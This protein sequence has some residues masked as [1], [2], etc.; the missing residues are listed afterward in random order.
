[1]EIKRGEAQ[2]DRVRVPTMVA[3]GA[4]RWL[5]ITPYFL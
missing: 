1:V 4:R 3:G 5:A 2:L